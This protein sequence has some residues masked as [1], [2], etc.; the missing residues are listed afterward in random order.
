MA[1]KIKKTSPIDIQRREDAALDKI[2][3]LNLRQE[4]FCNLYVDWDKEFFGNGVQTYLEVYYLTINRSKPNWYKTA[5]Q[6]AS[7]LLTNVKVC[8]R[9]NELLDESGY[10]D[11]F[12]DKQH[13]FLMTQ[14]SDLK[15][16]MRAI[17]HYNNKKGRI[18]KTEI[19]VNVKKKLTDEEKKNIKNM[20]REEVDEALKAHFAKN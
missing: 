8:N 12:A 6:A 18:A 20:T 4:K 11:E 1:K 9:I 3:K 16:K 13:L 15:V 7:R 10:N 14:C 17:E 5:T 2:T 19:D